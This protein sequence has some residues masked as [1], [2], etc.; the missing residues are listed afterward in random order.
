MAE[1]DRRRVRCRSTCREG[2]EKQ[3]EGVPAA[4]SRRRSRRIIIRGADLRG[5]GKRHPRE[6]YVEGA[7]EDK[8]TWRSEVTFLQG[9]HREVDKLEA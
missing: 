5:G 7:I 9:A 1:L 8:P 2:M 6:L 4:S 3:A